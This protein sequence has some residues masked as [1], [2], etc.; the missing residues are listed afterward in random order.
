[1]CHNCGS[2]AS[3]TGAHLLQAVLLGKTLQQCLPLRR[4][5][6]L[7]LRLPLSLRISKKCV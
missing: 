2:A 5:L 3:V 7:L 1:M 4:L 6:G